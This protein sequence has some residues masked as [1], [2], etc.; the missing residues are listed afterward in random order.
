MKI[1]FLA[2]V[3][4]AWI[5]GELPTLALLSSW[6]RF[7]RRFRSH[8]TRSLVYLKN[9]LGT[10]K[11]LKN[12]LLVL[13]TLKAFPWLSPALNEEWITNESYRPEPAS[14]SYFIMLIKYQLS[15]E[16][17]HLSDV[18]E[19]RTFSVD[20]TSLSWINPLVPGMQ[21]IKIRQ[22]IIEWFVLYRD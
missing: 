13:M 1:F 6:C 11:R 12:R 20:A 16:H 4:L 5:G 3:V 14:L 9:E 10:N 8:L 17:A 21:N 19:T 2:K 15:I 18:K 7:L 22:F